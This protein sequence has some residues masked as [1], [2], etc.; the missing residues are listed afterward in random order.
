MART[1][2]TY[3]ARAIVRRP[4]RVPAANT[5]TH[6]AP[7]VTFTGGTHTTRRAVTVFHSALG[8]QIGFVGGTHSPTKTSPTNYTV[9]HVAPQVTFSGGVHTASKSGLVGVALTRGH[10]AATATFTTASITPTS[11]VVFIAVS[12][13][14]AATTPPDVASISG[15]GGTWQAVGAS[16]VSNNGRNRLSLWYGYGCTGS[17]AITVTPT[18]PPDTN[19]AWEVFEFTGI[20]AGAGAVVLGNY[21]ATAGPAAGTSLSVT[22]N[23][24]ASPNNAYFVAVQHRTAEDVTPLNGATE[25]D[26]D[27]VNQVNGIEVNYLGGWTS[28]GMGGSWVTNGGSNARVVGVEVVSGVAAKLITHV[29]PAVTFGASIHT[30][31]KGRAVAHV[32]PAVTFTGGVHALVKARVVVHVAPAVTLTGGVHTVTTTRARTVAHVAPVI[33]FTGGVHTLTKAKR[34]T[35]VAAAITFTG[36]TATR[37]LTRAAVAPAVTFTGG[38][39]SVTKRRVVAHVAPAVSFVG[40]VHA[41]QKTSGSVPHPI[42]HVAPAISFAG[43]IASKTLAKALSAPAIAFFGGV[44]TTVAA[45]RVTH[46][47]PAVAFTGGLLAPTRFVS[48]GGWGGPWGSMP[49]GG[50]GTPSISITHLADGSD[51]GVANPLT[52]PA[53]AF[54]NN[55]LYLVSISARIASGTLQTTGLTGGGLTW[56]KVAEVPSGGGSVALSLWRAFV[57]SGA[58]TGA[59]TITLNSP[60]TSM[61]WSVDEVTGVDTSGTNGS[62]AIVQSTT[63]SLGSGTQT[64]GALA[65]FAD[66]T[67]NAAFSVLQ[68]VS[69]ET[70]NVDATP[71]W[72][73]LGENFTTVSPAQSIHSAWKTGQDTSIVWTWATSG[74]YRDINVELKVG[75]PVG[76]AWT[77]THVAP[78]T[79]F[80]GGTHALIKSRVISHAAPAISFIGGVHSAQKTSG[81]VPHPVAHVAPA[82]T[83][84]GG[85]HALRKDGRIAHVAAAITFTGATAQ[86]A[87][88]KSLSAPAVAF[89]GGVHAT[90]AAHKVAHTAPQ[91]TLTGGT[92]SLVKFRKVAHVAPAVTFTGGSHLATKAKVQ[93]AVAAGVSFVGGTATLRRTVAAVAPAVSFIG[94]VHAV[95]KRKVATHVAASVSFIGGTAKLALSKAHVAQAVSFSGGV[96]L[97]SRT[98]RVTHVAPAVTFTGGT[99]SLQKARQVALVAPAVSFQA[100]AARLVTTR[101]HTAAQVTFTGGVAITRKGKAVIATAPRVQYVGGTAALRRTLHALAPSIQFVGADLT[102]IFIPDNA[103]GP[104]EPPTDAIVVGGGHTSVVGAGAGTGARANGGKTGVRSNGSRT[105]VLVGTNHT[106]SR[107]TDG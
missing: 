75:A 19:N 100:G 37:A 66:P 103:G 52:T 53:Y 65:A 54:K 67:N 96:H 85:V 44:H 29:A 84:T 49:W 27:N 41:A 6:V 63:D 28:G 47:A 2:R 99:H 17:G 107:R 13:A 22:P 74:V 61:K 32:A 76:I 69:L 51:D 80:I 102:P 98:K 64:A 5:V 82:V 39:H 62:G 105:G 70:A 87:V 95:L 55:T 73:K 12:Y 106:D 92:H 46:V 79:S 45:H 10:P 83:F 43:G 81:S 68:K 94:G 36:G 9:T 21:K 56:V 4:Y 86:R 3:P 30:L 18:A 31:V 11:G 77:V 42:T 91:V 60:A 71:G 1:G 8:V 20:Q 16:V 38:T 33:T 34:V 35:H 72:T 58:T 25:I 24:Q 23:A 15:L 50:G 101:R 7:A 97:V 104:V 90:S 26:D 89:A 88:A 40:G 59:L 48:S 57:T 78:A 93:Q 14:N